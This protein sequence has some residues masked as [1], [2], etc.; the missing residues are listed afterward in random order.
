LWGC[1]EQLLVEPINVREFEPGCPAREKAQEESLKELFEQHLQALVMIG[2]AGFLH[3]R[4]PMERRLAAAKGLAAT[5]PFANE[6]T[7]HATQKIGV[8]Q[9]RFRAVRLM[10]SPWSIRFSQL[11]LATLGLFGP[12]LGW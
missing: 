8:R 1:E 12:V 5:E 9:R 6:A 4:L 11:H 3:D 2:T 7:R 10:A